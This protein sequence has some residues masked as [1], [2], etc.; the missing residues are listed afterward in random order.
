M[1][2]CWSWMKKCLTRK[3]EKRELEEDR[4]LMMKTARERK[5]FFVL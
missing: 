1:F 2:V 5:V 3:E 4:E